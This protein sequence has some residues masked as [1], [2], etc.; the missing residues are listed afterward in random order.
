MRGKEEK[1]TMR[2]QDENENMKCRQETETMKRNRFTLIELLVVISIISILASMLMPALNTAKEKARQ[3]SCINNQKQLGTGFVMYFGDSDGYF[4][5]PENESYPKYYKYLM[6]MSSASA[7]SDILW[8]ANDY[9]DK[10]TSKTKAAKFTDGWVSYGFN[11]WNLLTT[12]VS[13][14]AKP[15]ATINLAE[16]AVNTST[17]NPRGFFHVVSWNNPASPVVYPWHNGKSNILWVDGHVH[18]V[19]SPDRSYGGFYSTA[20]FG[21][22]KEGAFSSGSNNKWD[23]Y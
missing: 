6:D 23:I 20:V 8:C 15:S 13:N 9:N 19:Q 12:K 4:P 16:T 17:G 1:E 14:V 2:G 7:N 10:D 11:R 22:H 18:S 21:Y 3:I 5:N